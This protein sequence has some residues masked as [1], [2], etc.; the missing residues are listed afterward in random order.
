MNIFV[1]NL[2]DAV[3]RRQFQKQ[4][5]SEWVQRTKAKTLVDLGGNDGT[6][7]RCILPE[8]DLA[9]VADNDAN[10]VAQN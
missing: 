10:A 4:Q 7:A 8:M 2:S 5:L 1:I 9:I 3:E 6:F